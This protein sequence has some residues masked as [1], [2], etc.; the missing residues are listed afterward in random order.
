MAGLNIRIRYAAIT[1]FCEKGARN[2]SHEKT[3]QRVKY[4][5]VA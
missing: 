5:N 4:S 3:K 2:T 1:V